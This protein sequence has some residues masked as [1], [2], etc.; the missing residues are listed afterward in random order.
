MEHGPGKETTP[1]IMIDTNCR[2]NYRPEIRAR[3]HL[4]LFDLHDWGLILTIQTMR[5]RLDILKRALLGAN[6]VP[7][8]CHVQKVIVEVLNWQPALN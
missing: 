8:R 6:N 1:L 5:A 3:S 7:V 4:S 2:S